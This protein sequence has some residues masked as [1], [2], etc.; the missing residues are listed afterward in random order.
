[1]AAMSGQGGG[2]AEMS[3]TV[4]SLSPQAVTADIADNSN[5]SKS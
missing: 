1:M 2:K 4:V 3:K 5:Y